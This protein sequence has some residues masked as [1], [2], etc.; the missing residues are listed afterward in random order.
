MT[1]LHIVDSV[2]INGKDPVLFLVAGSFEPRSVQVPK[3]LRGKIDRAIIFSYDDTRASESGRQNLREIEV[4]LRGKCRTVSVLQCLV[5]D[6]FSVI[7]AF[8]TFITQERLTGE[9]RSVV[10]DATCFTKLHLLLL[11]RSLSDRLAVEVIR[12]CYTKPQVYA[13][14]FGKE[15]SYG[16]RKTGYIPYRGRAREG[17]KTGLIALLGHEPRRLERIVQEIEP[18]ICVVVI[19]EPGFSADMATYSRKVN[20]SLIRRAEYDHHFRLAYAPADDID[21]CID[22][23]AVQLNKL[24]ESRCRSVV[25]APFG[26]K[27]QALAVEVLTRGKDVGHLLLAYAIPDRYEHRVYSQ[28]IGETV[29]TTLE[30]QSNRPPGIVPI[31]KGGFVV[32]DY[33]VRELRDELGI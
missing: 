22:L 2:E 21:K 20:A 25:I 8:Q 12:I 13:T 17:D 24:H 3:M 26:T 11:L 14:A 9:I 4:C 16:I 7:G 19:G 5:S 6:P 33:D 1:T 27:L 30:D 15:L 28:G 23:L 18:D 10:V 32:T 29:I 31:P